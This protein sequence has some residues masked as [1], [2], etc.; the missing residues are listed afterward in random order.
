MMQ[1]HLSPRLLGLAADRAFRGD[2]LLALASDDRFL[3]IAWRARDARRDVVAGGIAPPDA[4]VYYHPVP[5]AGSDNDAL[6]RALGGITG[7][8][9]P[10]LVVSGAPVSSAVARPLGNGTQ[11][12]V[13]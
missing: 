11:P 4:T 1:A 12:V 13:R 7:N 8:E 9:A 5:A 2:T 6:V 10:V 3:G